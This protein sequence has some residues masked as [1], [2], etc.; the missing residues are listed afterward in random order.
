MNPNPF[1]QRVLAGAMILAP[2]LLLA[3]TVIAVADDAFA[4]NVPSGV[5][6]MF[7]MG[8]FFLAYLG[9]IGLVAEALPRLSTVLLVTGAFGAMAG[10]AFGVVIIA[11]AKGLE[12]QEGALEQ[13][14]NTP[15]ILFPMT[16]L[17]LGV[18][19][20]Y[21]KVAPLWTGVA[22]ALAGVGFPISR[23]G[24]VGEVAIV[25]DLLFL[26]ALC[27]LAT[28]VVRAPATRTVPDPAVT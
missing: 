12:L 8:A 23:I 5:L 7:A 22:L 4:E 28:V 6:L 9:V 27:G 1:Q 2:A 17:A 3:S 11:R 14:F 15:G 24:G 18:C 19:V 10:T 16:W 13:A 26:A 21:S 25:A 20:L